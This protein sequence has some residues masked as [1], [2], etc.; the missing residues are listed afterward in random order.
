[1][2]VA[3][4]PEQ[5]AA[6]F[7]PSWLVDKDLE[8]WEKVQNYQQAFT[9]NG[10]CQAALLRS[11]TAVHLKHWHCRALVDIFSLTKDEIL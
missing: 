10:E 4:D 7:T 8:C 5:P 6:W 9:R 2:D 11:P 3:L 1:M